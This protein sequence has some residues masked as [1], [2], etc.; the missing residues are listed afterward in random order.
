VI[1]PLLGSVVY[2]DIPSHTMFPTRFH[3]VYVQKYSHGEIVSS[4]IARIN[5]VSIFQLFSDLLDK[6]YIIKATYIMFNYLIQHINV[7]LPKG[8]I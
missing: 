4:G 8:N 2:T 6:I 7:I 1:R 5:I 3:A